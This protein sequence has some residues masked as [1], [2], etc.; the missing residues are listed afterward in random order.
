MCR[1][2]SKH[3][4]CGCVR[5]Y[6]R[7]RSFGR[8]VGR[9]LVHKIRI[10]F[11]TQIR[12]T[13]MWVPCVRAAAANYLY[14]CLYTIHFRTRGTDQPYR[15]QSTYIRISLLIL[16]SLFHDVWIHHI[17]SSASH[18]LLVFFFSLFLL[19]LGYFCCCLIYRVL[20]CVI[21]ECADDGVWA[22]AYRGEF[23]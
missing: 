6:A 10:I 20:L 13:C 7:S 2:H 18:A 23:L 14:I 16:L 11:H 4:L 15:E 1:A 9:S 5:V 21:V 22:R 8:S 12:N 17:L 3:C 19:C